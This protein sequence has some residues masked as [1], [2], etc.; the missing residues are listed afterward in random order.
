MLSISIEALGTTGI[1]FIDHLRIRNINSLYLFHPN[2]F[3]KF[4]TACCSRGIS[5]A[6]S[7]TIFVLKK[8]FYECVQPACYLFCQEGWNRIPNLNELL[9]AV[10]F[11]EVIVRERLEPGSF[12]RRQ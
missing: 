9:S 4:T 8:A 12:S 2:C 11:E 3:A 6:G 10:A 1:V 5:S 7:G